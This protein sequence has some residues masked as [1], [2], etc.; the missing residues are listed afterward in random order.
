MML[1]G[2]MASWG[3]IL[4]SSYSSYIM[5]GIAT[6]FFLLLSRSAGAYL[7]TTVG[8]GLF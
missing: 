4:F 3:R 7:S 2:I 8:G 1:M 5:G 6:S